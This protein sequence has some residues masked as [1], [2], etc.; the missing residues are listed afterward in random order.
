MFLFMRLVR[1]E[2]IF[3]FCNY[4]FSSGQRM[5]GRCHDFDHKDAH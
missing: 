2:I 5:V 1:R 4:F 3:L